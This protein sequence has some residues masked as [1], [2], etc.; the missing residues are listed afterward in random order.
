MQKTAIHIEPS[1]GI[2]KI[3]TLLL[4]L[5]VV[6]C[7]D[8]SSE[9][10][11]ERNPPDKVCLEDLNLKSLQNSLENCNQH[12]IHGKDLPKALNNRS[13]I[14]LLMGKA[15]LAC[16]DVARAIELINNEENANGSLIHDELKIRQNNCKQ[17]FIM[18]DN[19]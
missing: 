16:K 17:R 2:V 9:I 8:T 10:A 6:G 5:S 14:Y 12:I 18:I 11:L 1:F 4:S 19:D 7:S 13:I 15:E 3:A